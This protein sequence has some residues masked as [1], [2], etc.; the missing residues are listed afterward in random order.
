MPEGVGETMRN[1]KPMENPPMIV[2]RRNG[3]LKDRKAQV[4]THIS[5]IFPNSES[6]RGGIRLVGFL[7]SADRPSAIS[8]AK[9]WARTS[10]R[11]SRRRKGL[12]MKLIIRANLASTLPKVSAER[13]PR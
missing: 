8:D 11:Y 13:Y 1:K 6:S 7:G 9:V 3:I 12:T 2:P 5:N 10:L 4:S